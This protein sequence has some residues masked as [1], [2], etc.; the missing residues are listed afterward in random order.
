MFTYNEQDVIMNNPFEGTLVASVVEALNELGLDASARPARRKH[1]GGT[2]AVLTL[3]HAGNSHRFHAEVRR[4][5]T[6]SILGLV[7]LAFADAAEDR[8]LIADYVT[9]PVA[10]ELRR[11]GIQFA[12]SAGNAYLDRGGLFVFVTGRRP[13]TVKAVPRTARLF[14]S[15]GIKVIFAILSAPQLLEA[16]QRTIAS[17]AGVALG[18]VPVILQGLTESD[19][20]AEIRGARRLVHRERLV[21]E[22]TEAYLRV[23][24]PS[25]ELGRFS[26]AS[27][28]W[29]RLADLTVHGVQWGGET[30]AALLHRGLVP[31][32]AIIY[33]DGV[34]SRL[35]SQYRLKAD[36]AGSVV[37]R[38]RFWN[39]VP[40]PRADIVPPLLIYA[41][42][43]KTGDARSIDAAKMIR[44][45]Y[46]I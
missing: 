14:Q 24:E 43:V 27:P 3:R 7:T 29:W 34:P 10:D 21:K 38:R 8:L 40:G 39:E 20:L 5:L 45:A 36:P 1:D 12:D 22:W 37:L 13:Q 42:L 30:A 25:L 11:R 15:S 31:E 18:S 2:D 16:S 23:L 46:G 6:P 41:D 35:M 4:S 19:Y 44:D 32:R 17:A 33:T 26:A 28:D 9:P